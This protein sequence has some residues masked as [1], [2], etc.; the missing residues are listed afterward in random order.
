MAT[1]YKL[2][3]LDVG[4]KIPTEKLGSGTASASTFLRGDQTWATPPGSG[5]SLASVHAYREAPT[6]N[7]LSQ[8]YMMIDWTG[9]EWDTENEFDLDTDRYTAI[10]SGKRLAICNFYWSV[11]VAN[12]IFKVC[13]YKNGILLKGKDYQAATAATLSTEIGAVVDMA[14]NDYLQFYIYQS[15]TGNL[16]L[17]MTKEQTYLF[18][19]KLL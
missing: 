1:E 9:E 15:S 19:Q 13:I 3:V 16:N 4:N 2:P 6:F 7:V 10:T 18:I 12:K 14:V 5:G 17:S 8:T 11:T